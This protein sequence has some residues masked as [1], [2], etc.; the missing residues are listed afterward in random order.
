MSLVTS[1]LDFWA[2]SVL[3]RYASGDNVTNGT[4][5]DHHWRGVPDFFGLDHLAIA[6]F[7]EI[8]LRCLAESALALTGPPAF[9]PFRAMAESRS[10]VRFL[11]RARPP[12]GP[13]SLPSAT[14]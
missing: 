8:S 10:G 12:F 7:R 11:D 9:P 5:P 6:P 1:M 2:I 3:A 14:A 13:P 4:K